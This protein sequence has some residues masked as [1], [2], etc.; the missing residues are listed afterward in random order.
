MPPVTDNKSGA[1]DAD[2]L[3]KKYGIAANEYQLT[4][5]IRQSIE[6]GILENATRL[7]ELIK[8]PGRQKFILNTN[9]SDIKEIKQTALIEAFNTINPALSII[10]GIVLV[11][12]NK[13][14]LDHNLLIRQHYFP[15]KHSVQAGETLLINQNNYNYEVELLNGMLVKVVAADEASETKSHMRS[16][17][18]T[19]KECY[20][21]HR[22]RW[23][24]IEVPSDDGRI[25]NIRC[26]ILD[27]FLSSP[28]R[29]LDYEE[30]IALYIDFKF[31]HSHLKVKTAE[32][33]QAFRTDPYLNALKVKFGYA[34]TVHKAQGGE[35]ENVLV[36]MDF[37]QSYTSKAF[38]RWAY[39]AITR[40][41]KALTIF[42]LPSI[43]LF[44][45]LA[46]RDDRIVIGFEPSNKIEQ[47]AEK[48]MLR[49]PLAYEQQIDTWFVNTLPFIIEKYQILLAQLQEAEIQITG[50][51][52]R[53]FAEEYYFAQG[54]QQA[55]ITYYYNGK[56]KFT[57]VLATPGKAQNT[58]LLERVITLTGIP[59]DFL[60]E[61][62]NN[63]IVE[64]AAEI[65]IADAED[66]A[67]NFFTEKHKHLQP[68][69][70]SINEL[71]KEKEITIQQIEHKEYLE[72]YFISRGT[73]N[74][75][76]QFW[77]NGQNEFTTAAPHLPS[78]NS[79]ELLEDIANM[80]NEIL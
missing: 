59:I 28:K 74:A 10:D 65:I 76:I 8:L 2:Y 75:M 39:T 13:T 51:I 16:Y 54:N 17:D 79:N 33:T 41:S 32:F 30:N 40:A 71:L 50:R 64:V 67:T 49:L 36:D 35:W 37:Y 53:S 58:D 1:L 52:S 62:K 5:V 68:L 4:G 27:S 44:R 25:K 57:R 29:A 66:A 60:I 69:Y 72:R 21:S 45:H 61:S 73:Q 3:F 38:L 77:Y 70:A 43:S 78:C 6:S 12:R 14:A 15:D 9:F 42:N 24:T 63:P 18:A 55:I 80:M 46:Y 31:R 20:V 48:L 26:M 23:V 22:F 47:L 19:G 11:S 7:R 34:I 56:N